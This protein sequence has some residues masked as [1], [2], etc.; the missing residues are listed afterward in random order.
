MGLQAAA[1]CAVPL[2]SMTLVIHSQLERPAI[3]LLAFDQ[4]AGAAGGGVGVGTAID[5]CG[6]PP[7]TAALDETSVEGSADGTATDA[8]GVTGEALGA[9]L[10]PQATKRMAITATARARIV[11]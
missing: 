5:G 6:L 2:P 7:S 4:T 9:W 11:D 10:A 8:P 1:R 3:G